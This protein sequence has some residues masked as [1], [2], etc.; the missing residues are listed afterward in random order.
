MDLLKRGIGVLAL[1][2]TVGL[3]SA[4]CFGGDE[5]E[6]RF[7]DALNELNE[8]WELYELKQQ[9]DKTIMMVEVTDNVTFKEGQEAMKRVLAIDPNY[10]GMIEFYNSEVGMT[11]RKVEVFPGAI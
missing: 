9:G 10:T 11:L 6:D 1:A 8:S 7:A 2:L 5:V 4:G 3:L